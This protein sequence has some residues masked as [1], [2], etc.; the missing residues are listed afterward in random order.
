MLDSSNLDTH[1]VQRIMQLHGMTDGVKRTL[2]KY[3]AKINAA[4]PKA[5]AELVDFIGSHGG[6]NLAG[7]RGGAMRTHIIQALCRH[8]SIAM[9]GDFGPDYI[10]SVQQIANTH[11][12]LRVDPHLQMAAYSLLRSS[13]MRQVARPW[14]PSYFNTTLG[15]ALTRLVAFDM[16]M[17]VSTYLETQMNESA[18]LRH[19]MSEEFRNSLGHIMETLAAAAEQTSSN[20][21]QASSLAGNMA[22]SAATI[23]EQMTAAT[24]MSASASNKAVQAAGQVEVLSSKVQDISEAIMRISKIAN[25]TNLLALNASIEAARAGSVGRGFSVVA[26]EVKN[27]AA[28]TQKVTD[29]INIL[30][31]AIKGETAQA[32][33]NVHSVNTEIKALNDASGQVQIA[34]GKQGELLRVEMMSNIQQ[35]QTGSESLA[36]QARSLRDTAE[37]FLRR[38]MGSGS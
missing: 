2:S 23:R 15:D 35:S 27:L 5:G 17:A 19:T 16:D 26:G 22:Q 11:N 18:T 7:D 34:L 9:R 28:Q 29:D 25:Q 3:S 13:I 8:W 20:V 30:L 4:M 36:K 37:D 33:D 38:I 6:Y 31:E 10:A 21:R 14:V 24:N 32:V 12:K 1:R